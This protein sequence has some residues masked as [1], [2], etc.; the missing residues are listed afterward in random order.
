MEEGNLCQR[1]PASRNNVTGQVPESLRE[2]R[3]QMQET[4][5]RKEGDKCQRLPAGGNDRRGQVPETTCRKEARG[6]VPEIAAKESKLKESDSQ[7]EEGRINE[8]QY[9]KKKKLEY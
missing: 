3:E 8:Q 9:Q 2:G 7:K 5:C 6:Q 1:L 4:A